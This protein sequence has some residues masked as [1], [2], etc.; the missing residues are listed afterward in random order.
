MNETRG[1]L[2]RRRETGGFEQLGERCVTSSVLPWE[3]KR[4]S[5]LAKQSGEGVA[6]GSTLPPSGACKWVLR[7]LK[8]KKVSDIFT[9]IMKES[10]RL[11]RT[12]TRENEFSTE[13]LLIASVLSEKVRRSNARF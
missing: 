1:L 10:E 12:L 4:A 5:A 2:L 7:L 3:R 11:I 8:V 13:L 9:A 6:G